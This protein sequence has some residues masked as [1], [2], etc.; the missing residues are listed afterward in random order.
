M[1]QKKTL[2]QKKAAFKEV[3]EIVLKMKQ[4]L[5]W[6][7]YCSNGMK[8]ICR[9]LHEISV[10][11]DKVPEL[12]NGFNFGGRKQIFLS[13][14]MEFLEENG[15]NK[16]GWNRTDRGEFVA[17]EKVFVKLPKSSSLGEVIGTKTVREYLDG[18]NNPGGD[19]SESSLRRRHPSENE[20]HYIERLVVNPFITRRYEILCDIVKKIDKN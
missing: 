16:N 8:Q 5:S 17:P 12:I 6:A 11:H 13:R 14:L 3:V 18:K 19:F 7:E 4:N 2:K 20:T 10:V 9:F 15:R 1:K